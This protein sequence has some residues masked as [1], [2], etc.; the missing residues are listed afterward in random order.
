RPAAGQVVEFNRILDNEVGIQPEGAATISHNLLSGNS[1]G[2]LIGGASQVSLV[3]N[4]IVTPSGTGIR[5][6]QSASNVSLRNN[7]LS[8]TSGTGLYVATD[9]QQGF[10]SDY[11]NHHTSGA[12]T[13]I[14][15][16]KP[17]A[18]LFD[19]QVEAD[20]D[21]HSIGTTA[22]AP[23]RDAPGFMDAAA[24]NYRLQTTSTSVDAGDPTDLYAAEPAV[25]GNRIDLGAY[26]NTTEATQSAARALRLEYPEYYADWPAAEGRPILW[27]SYDS[28]TADK[29]MAGSVKI[30][31]FQQGGGLVTQ[32]AMV[33]AADGS[34]GWSPE[35]SGIAG[36][37]TNR[38]SI[39]ISSV[40]NPAL[41][42]E[43]REN[44]S[45]PPSG[46]GFYV[47]DGSPTGDEWTTVVGN[48]RNTGKSVGDPKANLLPLLRSYDLGPGDTVRIDTGNYIH[49]RNVVLSGNPLLGND[50]GLT[51]TGPTNAAKV[52]RIDR[53]NPYAGSTNIELN[54]ADFVTLRNLT[55]TGAGMG[56]WVRED[57][58]NFQGN[59]LAASGN[60]T[61][62]IRID[63]PIGS[64]SDSTA[65]DNGGAGI[66]LNNP[67]PAQVEA[68]RVSGNRYGIIVS[69]S[70]A[71]D[72]T[73]IGNTDLSLAR[74]NLVWGNSESG[75][76]ASGNALVVGN[77]VWGHSSSSGTGIV[78]GLYAAEARHNV[79]Y[80]NTLG[81]SGAGRIQG[82]R[83]YHN[84]SVGIRAYHW[85]SVLENVV[86]GNTVGI[87]AP[88]SYP[89]FH[90]ELLNNLVYANSVVGIH[91][92][93]G[94]GARVINN[95]VFQP[96]GNALLID[97]NSLNTSLFNNT[98]WVDSGFNII[99]S[100]DSQVG[101]QSDFNLLH[102]TGTGQVAFWQGLP[103]STLNAW[104]NTVFQD[105][106]SLAQ[107]PRFV[108]PAGPDGILGYRVSPA[109][110]F[111]AD[112]DFHEQSDFGSFHG[113][114]LAPLRNLATDLPVFATGTWTVD[115]L[116]SPAIDRGRGSD[117]Y[118]NEPTNNGRFRNLGAFGNTPQA[119]KS[120]AEYVLVTRPDGG[121]VWPAQQTFP[122]RWRSH[123]TNGTVDIELW[124]QDGVSPVTVIAADTPNDGEYLWTI[125]QTIPEGLDY[126]VRIVRRDNPAIQDRSGSIFEITPPVTVYYVNDGSTL[127]D[128]S[129]TAA[130]DNANTGLA[131]NAPKASVAAI[132]AAYDLG[133]GDIIR[134]DVGTYNL[135][136]N[137]VIE[138]QD[139]GVRIEGPA[140]GAAV[141]D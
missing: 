113:G 36:S 22:P 102:T 59:R 62:G 84:S 88:S 82:N 79:V 33:P 18:D 38:Y 86:Y 108:N 4:T 114:S 44:F 133:P 48:N 64:L 29:K 21:R 100:G 103:K 17:F 120:P 140:V 28:S 123:D 25:N 72:P 109:G 24:G 118:A 119:S 54:D 136:G 34:Y 96:H 106:N 32:I 129:T 139:S 85:T 105:E 37:L 99:V 42:D 122:I 27:S 135:S 2:V 55:L 19:W 49:V 95:T 14:W 45:V 5:L 76:V 77:T 115:A 1:T 128:E 56:L 78:L 83:V 101:F 6:Q 80:D 112:D 52:A 10:T 40:E 90:G 57:S 126:L 125:P 132:L 138:T 39:R 61:D 23:N 75:I 58:S 141:L 127:G 41:V 74:G 81:I 12:A 97:G 53:A 60:T 30:E 35:M 9:S 26:G 104:Y 16:Q 70:P 68:N 131:P 117:S 31:L 130:G 124:R 73:V 43:S 13:L 98:L 15:W 92:E 107:D 91:I 50:E 7:I 63:S 116:R 65:F 46:T 89:R 8:T 67:G 94:A 47:N 87:E 110:D 93:S 51:I 69:N 66:A 111:G 71:G 11:N 137:L 3:N 20:L 134:V 121:E